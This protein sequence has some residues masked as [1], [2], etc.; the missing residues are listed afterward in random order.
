M[1]KHTQPHKR[2][3]GLGVIVVIM[4][5]SGF[6]SLEAA[7]TPQTMRG[8][9]EK[10]KPWEPLTTQT[11]LQSG[12]QIRTAHDAETSLVS[13][14]GSVFYL[15]E[16]T[17]LAVREL[18]YTPSQKTRV[19]RLQLLWGTLTAKASTL[20][21]KKDVFEVETNTVLTAFQRSSARF[22]RNEQGTEINPIEG[23]FFLTTSST[24]P[25]G[26][27][28]LIKIGIQE[29][30]MGPASTLKIQITAGRKIVILQM[31]GT[32][33]YN[34]QQVEE[35]QEIGIEAGGL[36]LLREGTGEQEQEEFE[37]DPDTFTLPPDAELP[38]GSDTIP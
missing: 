17:Q 33:T 1:K 35:G 4:A 9:V 3:L 34:G 11:T 32:V 29:I 30:E 16:G 24:L 19:S 36:Q 26:Q 15:S 12:D 14:D 37:I 7:L 21:F 23:T 27:R 5:I 20:N 6:P 31:Q 22:L 13:D 25:T 10:G 8:S 28:V 38:A 2:L 18:Q